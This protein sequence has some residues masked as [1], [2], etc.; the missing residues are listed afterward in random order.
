MLMAGDALLFRHRLWLSEKISTYLLNIIE[1]YLKRFR[2]ARNNLNRRNPF[3]NLLV[4]S[5]EGP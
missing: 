2:M 1:K 3:L 5:D 4:I